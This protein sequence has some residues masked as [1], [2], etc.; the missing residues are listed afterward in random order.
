MA[1]LTCRDNANA[2]ADCL[3]K[4][5]GKGIMETADKDGQRITLRRALSTFS[6]RLAEFIRV[7]APVLS[8]S[9]IR[10]GSA[11]MAQ[12]LGVIFQFC[13]SSSTK[14]DCQLR[15]AGNSGAHRLIIAWM[16]LLSHLPCGH[17]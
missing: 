7:M 12:S 13:D 4:V 6:V 1:L 14:A 9:T 3:I 15:V 2:C 8:P 10:H 11:A 17:M 5:L 16:G